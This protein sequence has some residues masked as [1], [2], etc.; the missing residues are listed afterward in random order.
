MLIKLDENLP[1]RLVGLLS[2]FGHEAVTVAEEGLRGRDDDE[3]WR[4]ARSENRFLMTQDLDFSDAR[5]FRPGTH[6]GIL[7]LRLAQPGREALLARMESVLRE[8]DLNDWAG[9]IAVVSDR[10]VR[11]LRPKG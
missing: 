4:A 10:K 7:L 11:V 6:A 8:F 5:E 3:V 1:K 9:C 2:G